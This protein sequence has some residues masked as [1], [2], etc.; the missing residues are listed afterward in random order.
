LQQI[1]D[2]LELPML[3][4]SLAWLGLFL[5]ELTWG[6]T[7]RQLSRSDKVKLTP[8]ILKTTDESRPATL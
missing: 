3:V 2:W 1:E 8:K 4:L 5:V 7:P 6:L